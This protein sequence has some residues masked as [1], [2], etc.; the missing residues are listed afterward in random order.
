[1]NMP[2]YDY[3]VSGG[4]SSGI[5]AIRRATCAPFTVDEQTIPGYLDFW[6]VQSTAVYPNPPPD[7]LVGTFYLTSEGTL[8]FVA[9]PRPSAISSIKVAGSI[10][11]IKFSTIVG[12]T[13]SIAYTG[14]L[15]NPISTW[16]V[17]GNSLIGN[18]RISVINHTNTN[19]NSQ[20]F[21]QVKTQ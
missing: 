2:S 7:S 20:E 12:N 8:T 11:S 21:Y 4:H 16:P 13:Y 9:G 14:V 19:N 3:I 1:M 5:L 15:G 10:S 17:D 18:G 6:Q